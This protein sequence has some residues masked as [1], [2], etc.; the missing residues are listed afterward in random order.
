MSARN[1]F[2]RS[3]VSTQVRSDA[4]ER[5]VHSTHLQYRDNLRIQISEK[6]KAVLERREIP[7]S[8]RRRSLVERGLI[9]QHGRVTK[10]A[11]RIL[12]LSNRSILTKQ[13]RGH[14]PRGKRRSDIQPQLLDEFSHVLH[15]AARSLSVREIGRRIGKDAKTVS[16]WVHG[17]AWPTEESA[18]LVISRLSSV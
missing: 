18:R 14:W 3:F 6:D 10:Y 1:R 8:I 16:R 11:R 4:Y 13:P 9:D 2:R 12:G 5:G 17:K 15:T 7:S